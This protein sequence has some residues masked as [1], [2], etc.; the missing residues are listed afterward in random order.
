LKNTKS[1]NAYGSN[2]S[3]IS[4]SHVKNKFQQQKDFL[5]DTSYLYNKNTR[6]KKTK[7]ESSKEKGKLKNNEKANKEKSLN[8]SAAAHNYN[9]ASRINNKSNHFE[10]LNKSIN[11]NNK[12]RSIAVLSKSFEQ[13]VPLNKTHNANNETV[14]QQQNKYNFNFTEEENEF[15]SNSTTTKFEKHESSNLNYNT[16]YSNNISHLNGTNFPSGD[17]NNKFNMLR[18]FDKKSSKNRSAS[19]TRN[20]HAFTLKDRNYNN[21][22]NLLNNSTSSNKYLKTSNYNNPSNLNMSNYSKA[23]S[24]EAK[25]IKKGFSTFVSVRD[26]LF[27]LKAE[28]SLERKNLKLNEKENETVFNTSM[29]GICLLLLSSVIINNN[30]F[31]IHLL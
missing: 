18:S 24:I 21:I 19:K 23:K 22:S 3:N 8:N 20:A 29:N 7:I 26:A 28:K 11:N 15:I 2:T 12:E 27:K 4:S 9:N 14:K 25:D 6:N 30:L 31:A 5:Y 17:N 1:P 16:N 13:I 10:G